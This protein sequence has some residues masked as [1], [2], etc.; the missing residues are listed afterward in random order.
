M[1][2]PVIET[3]EHDLQDAFA[4]PLDADRCGWWRTV[5]GNATSIPDQDLASGTANE[6]E[7]LRDRVDHYPKGLKWRTR[8]NIGDRAR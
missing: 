3:T 5:E 7:R 8:A 2:L 1:K 4:L 6:I